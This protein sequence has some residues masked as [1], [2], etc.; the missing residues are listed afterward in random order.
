[1]SQDAETGR[2][3]DFLLQEINREINTIGSKASHAEITK[4]VV[5]MKSQLEKLR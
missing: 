1:F 2:K 4:N 5:E 3:M